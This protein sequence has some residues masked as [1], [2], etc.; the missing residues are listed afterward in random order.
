MSAE[1]DSRTDLEGEREAHRGGAASSE[2][3]GRL[4]AAKSVL[5]RVLGRRGEEYWSASEYD[6]CHAAEVNA[7]EAWARESGCWLTSDE[8]LHWDHSLGMGEHHLQQR[9]DRVYKATKKVRFGVYPSCLGRATGAPVD[10]LV[11]RLT[12]T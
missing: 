1:P 12:N 3:D 10:Q 8:W 5:E 7:L 2:A 6:S 11:A 9:G 4:A